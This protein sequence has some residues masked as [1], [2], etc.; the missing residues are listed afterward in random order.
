MAWN[1]ISPLQALKYRRDRNQMVIGKLSWRPAQFRCRRVVARALGLAA[2]SSKKARLQ[3]APRIAISKVE[4]AIAIRSSIWLRRLSWP[5]AHWRD[6]FVRR[7]ISAT[8]PQELQP[9]GLNGN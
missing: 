7:L 6:S 9:D 4:W 1:F 5:P 8:D 2:A 3:S